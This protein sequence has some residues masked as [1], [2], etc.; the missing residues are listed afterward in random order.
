MKHELH[1]PAIAA[2]ADPASANRLLLDAL[3]SMPPADAT[4]AT[5]AG[6]LGQRL[7]CRA[8]SSLRAAAAF[9]TVRGEP[10]W[11]SADSGV[12]IRW[13]Y[14]ALPGRAP[15]VGEPMRVRQIQLPRGASCQLALQPGLRCEWLV[16]RGNACIDGVALQARDYH[17]VLTRAAVALSSQDGAW[18]YLR[19]ADDVDGPFAIHTVHDHV[20][21]WSPHVPG[22]ERRVLWQRGGEAA[23]MYRVQRGAEVPHHGH[24]HDEECL[25]LQGEVFVDDIL[26]GPGDYQLAPA[27]TFHEGVCCDTGGIL[28]THGDIELAVTPR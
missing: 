8:A 4:A 22:I 10:Q 5:A 9:H 28:L 27:G 20:A 23:L 21:P 2:D 19:E 18:L 13:L 12:R 11:L 3:A 24:G 1:R 17:V 25:M 26:L 6:T 16:M 15:R 7:M 14:R